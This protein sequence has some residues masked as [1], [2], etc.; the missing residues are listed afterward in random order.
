MQVGLYARVSTLRGQHPE[1]Q[2]SDL[3]E[4]A[5]RRGLLGG[6]NVQGQRTATLSK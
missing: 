6:G 1:M 3:R 5:A 2:L 4:Y